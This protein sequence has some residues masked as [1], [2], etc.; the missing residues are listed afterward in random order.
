[1]LKSPVS[2]GV[3]CG[4]LRAVSLAAVLLVGG[5]SAA[6]AAET[7][8]EMHRLLNTAS[9]SAAGPVIGK[10]VLTETPDGVTLQLNLSELPPGPNRLFLHATGDCGAQKGERLIKPLATVNVDNNEGG[11]GPLRTRRLVPGKT[12]ADMNGPALG[13]YRG[14]Q[15]ADSGPEV[16][17]QPRLVACGV[18]Q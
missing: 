2:F 1:M 11:A 4:P 10:V 17:S 12:L 14:S 8:V 16:T 15:L 3:A 5:A 7:T 18:I 6:F 9:G 13:C